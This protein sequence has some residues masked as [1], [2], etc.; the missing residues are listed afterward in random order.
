MGVKEQVFSHDMTAF[1]NHI[2]MPDLGI[3]ENMLIFYYIYQHLA[4]RQRLSNISKGFI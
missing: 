1:E 2:F 4:G 3:I